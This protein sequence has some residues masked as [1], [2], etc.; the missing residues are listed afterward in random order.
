MNSNLKEIPAL[1]G[2]RGFAF[3]LVL[4]THLGEYG[5]C[6]SGYEIGQIGVSLFFTLSGFLMAYHYL[7]GKKSI[8]Y[9]LV[10]LIRR[11]FRVYPAYFVAVTLMWLGS[12]YFQSLKS[13]QGYS[14]IDLWMLKVHAPFDMPFWT[15]KVELKFY[16][17]FFLFAGILN[18]VNIPG[19]FSSLLWGILTF[20]FL[21][22]LQN[23][24]FNYFL[25]F[26]GGVIICELNK[27]IISKARI[28]FSFADIISCSLLF[29]LLGYIAVRWEMHHFPFATADIFRGW[30]RV[31]GTWFVPLFMLFVVAVKKSNGV[32]SYIFSS[33]VM[34]FIGN[35]SYSLYLTHITVICIF[36]GYFHSHSPLTFLSLLLALVGIA[37]V[38]YTIIEKP[39]NLLGKKLA[40]KIYL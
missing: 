24:M 18:M 6:L 23:T 34:R 10:F 30:V 5:W 14:I 4:F 39:F 13:Y 16:F 7:P 25:F 12:Q 32:S 37:Y 40:A 26:I 3:I 21:L 35:I 20:L 11:I 33:R 17:Y 27:H 36:M 28:S 1:D 38:F 29:T 31:H 22:T 2:L 19:K 15:I 8:Y 9:W